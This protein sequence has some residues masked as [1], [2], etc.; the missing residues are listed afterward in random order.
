MRLG[1]VVTVLGQHEMV[2]VALQQLLENKTNPET[3]IIVVDNGGDFQPPAGVSLSQ[4]S[5]NLGVYPVFKYA[6]DNF[7]D[8]DVLAFLHSDVM[9]VEKGFDQ[10]IIDS[11]EARKSLGM[12]G[13]IGS[14]EIDQAGGRGVGTMGNFQGFT[15]QSAGASPTL[16]WQ[17]SPAEAHGR[18]MA[19]EAAAAVVDGCVMIIRREAWEDI[20]YR[21]DFPPHHFYDRLISTQLL[22]RHWAIIVMGVA[23]DHL[24]GQTVSRE[25]RYP[26]MAQEWCRRRNI[27]ME[28]N[29]DNTVY[30]HAEIAWLR[31]YRDLKHLVPIRV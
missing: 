5:S 4:P 20:G 2:R 29:W 28:G 8:F 10:R 17:G 18:R 30:K 24:G 26:D 9:V 12:I 21:E 22:E 3:E 7:T 19:A 27:L 25:Q 23:F 15:Y 11:F 13:F 16:V 1:I 6:F 31:E 14:N